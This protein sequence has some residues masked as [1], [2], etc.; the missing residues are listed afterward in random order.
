MALLR[1][2][3]TGLAAGEERRATAPA[4]EQPPHL[5]LAP[6]RSASSHRPARAAPALAPARGPARAAPL[7]GR[8]KPPPRAL[9]AP[10]AGV[11]GQ[12]AE[13]SRGER[14]PP[15]SLSLFLWRLGPASQDFRVVLFFLLILTEIFQYS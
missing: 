6:P 12:A 2:P 3:L 8:P 11:A 10:P 9:G 5:V 15:L 4:R 14:P 7:A 1:P 13:Q